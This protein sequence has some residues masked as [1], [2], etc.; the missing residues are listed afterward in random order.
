MKTLD[1]KKARELFEN[2]Y[3]QRISDATWY[4]LKKVFDPATFPMSQQHIIW[5][6]SIKKQLP[7]CDLRFASVVESVRQTQQFIKGKNTSISGGELLK[8]LADYNIEIHPNTLTKWF[9]PL[10]GFSRK[11][12][13]TFDQLTPVILAA[14]TYKLRQDNAKLSQSLTLVR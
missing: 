10:N 6:A 2:R 12:I 13:Y 14:H 7:K 4:R 1:G 9:R 5:L 3:G 11:R 8:F